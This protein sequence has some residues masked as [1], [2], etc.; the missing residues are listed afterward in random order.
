M[1]GKVIDLGFIMV[2]QRIDS[3]NT[4]IFQN[5]ERKFDDNVKYD[6]I[7]KSDIFEGR[8]SDHIFHRNIDIY[9]LWINRDIFHIS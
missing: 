5:I 4:N 8:S 9:I 7:E 6:T 1:I 3:R 2:F